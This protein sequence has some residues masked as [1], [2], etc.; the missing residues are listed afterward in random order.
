[1]NEPKIAVT[2][3]TARCLK[4]G[5]SGFYGPTSID[6]GK[7]WSCTGK[8]AVLTRAGKFAQKR[9]QAIMAEMMTPMTEVKPGDLAYIQIAHI[10][11]GARARAWVTA[12]GVEITES[13]MKLDGVPQRA[14]QIQFDEGVRLAGYRGFVCSPAETVAVKVWNASTH[15]R[16]A[17]SIANLKGA[18]VTGL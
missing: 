14:A 10:D 5:G 6:S 1:M 9:Y 11:T 12:T 16:A 17:E 13:G 15:R 2:F 4:C 3:E 8:G 7:C 18:T